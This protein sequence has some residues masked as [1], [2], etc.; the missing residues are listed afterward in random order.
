MT[1]RRDL[2]HAIAVRNGLAPGSAEEGAFIK[3]CFSIEPGTFD[4][5]LSRGFARRHIPAIRDVCK[6]HKLPFNPDD[7]C[8]SRQRDWGGDA[9]EP[10]AWAGK[11]IAGV[12]E[13]YDQLALLYDSATE[14]RVLRVGGIYSRNR[15]SFKFEEDD[16]L[17]AEPEA[18]SIRMK[19]LR[20]F[21]KRMRDGDLSGT[22]VHVVKTLDRL[23][24]L[25]ACLEILRRDKLHERNLVYMAPIPS[26]GTLEMPAVGMR[27]VDSNKTLLSLPAP[28]HGQSHY[29]SWI[30]SDRLA[31]FASA[32]INRVRG[33]SGEDLTNKTPVGLEAIMRS[34]FDSLYATRSGN[35][36][37]LESFEKVKKIKDRMVEWEKGP[38]WKP[39]IG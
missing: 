37:I 38:N 33:I 13:F 32:Y 3:R 12:G 23:A 8:P 27:I 6:A 25:W 4:S 24:E 11:P 36:G 15:T 17:A 21:W 10:I 2:W 30:E 29:S 18:P 7:W 39:V 31:T 35:Y 5:N 22:S 34:A 16:P 14:Y 19:Y 1:K 26:P 9:R 28:V 20:L